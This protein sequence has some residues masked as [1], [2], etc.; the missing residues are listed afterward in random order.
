MI[1]LDVTVCVILNELLDFTKYYFACFYNII[2][3]FGFST[4]FAREINVCN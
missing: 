2:N 1:Q 4:C 3:S